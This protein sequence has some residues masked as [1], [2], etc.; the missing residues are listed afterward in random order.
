MKYLLIISYIFYSV[1]SAIGQTDIEETPQPSKKEI[2][3]KGGYFKL[4]GLELPLKIF[5]P[6]GRAMLSGDIGGGY[7]FSKHLGL[8]INA[9]FSGEVD[10]DYADTFFGLALEARFRY[11]AW[12]STIDIG[13]IINYIISPNDGPY[14]ELYD[15]DFDVFYRYQLAYRLKKKSAFIVGLSLTYCSHVTINLEEYDTGIYIGENYE[16]GNWPGFSIFL[17]IGLN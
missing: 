3:R 5:I 1:S 2:Y 7:M 17:G 10:D 9:S 15:K 6:A 4:T 14:L 13:K 12:S 16:N 8:G 11:K